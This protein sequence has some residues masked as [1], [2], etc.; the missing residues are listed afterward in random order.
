MNPVRHINAIR[1][2][3]AKSIFILSLLDLAKDLRSMFSIRLTTGYLWRFVW[4]RALCLSVCGSASLGWL[5][6]WVARNTPLM[7]G[8]AQFWRDQ[9]N[10]AQAGWCVDVLDRLERANGRS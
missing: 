2:A 1:I 8:L 7:L 10:V 5:A 9:G 4:F 3:D 6:P